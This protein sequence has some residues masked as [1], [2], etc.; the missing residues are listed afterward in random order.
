MNLI[1]NTSDFPTS[2]LAKGFEVEGRRIIVAFWRD[3]FYV[4]LN[5]CPHRK[6]PLEW[7]PDQ[8]FDYEKQFLQCATHDALFRVEDGQCVAGPCF[9]QSLIALPF[10]QRGEE[11]WVDIPSSTPPTSD[12]LS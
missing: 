9:G 10:E 12:P 8:F 3:E 1:C 4:Y 2:P 5:R 11:V 6:I 7:S